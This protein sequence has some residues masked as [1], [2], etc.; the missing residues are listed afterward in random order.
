MTWDFVEASP[1][2]AGLALSAVVKKIANSLA[3]LPAGLAGRS[4]QRSCESWSPRSGCSIVATDPPYYANVGYADLSDFFYVWLRRM[5]KT[6]FP[7]VF[8]TLMVPKDEELIA[9]PFRHGG[10][11]GANRFFLDGMTNA[12]GRLAANGHADYPIVV[13]Y[14]ARQADRGRGRESPKTGLGNLS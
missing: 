14:A 9:N 11:E 3:R 2:R 13:Y 4:Y 8:A 10:K 1:L 12:M 6:V 5:L 7:D